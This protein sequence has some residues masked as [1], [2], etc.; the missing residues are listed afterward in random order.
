[1][2]KEQGIRDRNMIRLESLVAEEIEA[3]L[4]AAKHP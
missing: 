3:V 1:M 2:L 4:A